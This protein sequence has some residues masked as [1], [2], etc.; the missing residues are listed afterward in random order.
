[1]TKTSGNSSRSSSS[2]TRALE[3]KV[4]LAE[5]E[6][7]EAFLVRRQIADNEAEKLKI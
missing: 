5:L 7:E 2:K 3:E 4:K 6:A 1:M